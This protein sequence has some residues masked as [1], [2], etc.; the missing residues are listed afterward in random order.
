MWKRGKCIFFDEVAHLLNLT[1]FFIFSTTLMQYK[2]A[3]V[4]LARFDQYGYKLIFE[5]YIKTSNAFYENF[6]NL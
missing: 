3:D 6:G 1:Y 2:H 4:K 5:I